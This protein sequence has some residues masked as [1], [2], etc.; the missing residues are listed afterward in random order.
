L[1]HGRIVIAPER[2]PA[3]DDPYLEFLRERAGKTFHVMAYPGNAGDELIRL[4]TD[5]ILA[6]RRIRTTSDPAQADVILVPGGNPTLWPDIGPERWQTVW[7]RYWHAEFVVGPAGYRDGYSNWAQTVNDPRSTVTGLFARDP[8]GFRCLQS[9]GLRS[10]ITYGLAF[11]P[12]L[13]LRT[14]DWLAAH[15][16]AASEEYD[17]A[18]FRNDRETNLPYP[19]LWRVASSIVPTRFHRSLIRALTS[20]VR[21]RKTQMAAAGREATAL[22]LVCND[23]AREPFDMFVQK[24]RAARTVH[25]DRL[26]TMLLAA[27]LGKKVF[28]YPTSH[29]KL[30]G[31][32]GYSL[33]GWADVTFVAM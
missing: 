2:L 5:Q 8:E 14:S 11:D 26:H 25:T 18:V 19:A 6:D 28:A 22:P 27:M 17:L 12:A 7:T 23:V 20:P 16:R 15:R 33:K 10:G 21:K 1:T 24:V 13:Y 9:A 31:V 3:H 32:Y 4:A 29:S 30:E